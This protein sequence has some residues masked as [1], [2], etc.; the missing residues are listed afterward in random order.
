MRHLILLLSALLPAQLW[1]QNPSEMGDTLPAT[2]MVFGMMPNLWDLPLE[3]QDT[4]E[5]LSGYYWKIEDTGN[6]H[7]LIAFESAGGFISFYPFQDSELNGFNEE[8]RIET[9]E[10]VGGGQPELLV[11]THYHDAN[12]GFGFAW[13]DDLKGLQIWD[14]DQQTRLCEF[15]WSAEHEGREAANPEDDYSDWKE[16]YSC[17]RYEVM[18]KPGSLMLMPMPGCKDEGPL[19]PL[20]HFK[21]VGGRWVRK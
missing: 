13:E 6:G 18:L 2:K 14:L 10:L 15:F 21:W 5:E 17:F 3:R 8:V 7:G 9:R 1:A 16:D 12:S 19:P 4:I 11:W 20:L